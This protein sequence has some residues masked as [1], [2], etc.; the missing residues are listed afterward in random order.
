MRIPKRTAFL[1][2]FGKGIVA[3]KGVSFMLSFCERRCSSK[4]C[5]FGLLL[6]DKV[7]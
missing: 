1:V 5:D 6:S 4:A 2:E 7:I 3:L